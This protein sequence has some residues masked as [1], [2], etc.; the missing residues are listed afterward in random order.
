MTNG[1][2]S[3]GFEELADEALIDHLQLVFT[4]ED[5]RGSDGLVHEETRAFACRC[6]LAAATGDDLDDH[7]LEAFTPA[8]GVGRDGRRHQVAGAR[9]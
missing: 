9:S 6:G 2:C 4:P 5:D 1:K 7:L 3:C 8:D